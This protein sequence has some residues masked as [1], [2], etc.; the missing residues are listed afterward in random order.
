MAK[1]RPA[2]AAADTK[3]TGVMSLIACAEAA[4]GSDA[5]SDDETGVMKKPS[6]AVTGEGHGGK[7]TPELALWKKKKRAFDMVETSG[8]GNPEF[9]TMVKEAKQNTL[10]KR[11]RMKDI[12][13]SCIEQDEK[14]KFFLVVQNPVFADWQTK[15]EDKYGDSKHTATTRSFTE[16]EIGGA[17]K[18]EEALKSGEVVKQMVKGRGYFQKHS[19]ETGTRCG[20]KSETSVGGQQAITKELAK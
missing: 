12:V 5:S 6:G 3:P 19:V 13:E 15:Y 11:Q 17:A 16:Q 10:G 7:Y 14:G 2:S 4:V 18:L 9:A 1:K 20:A 8:F